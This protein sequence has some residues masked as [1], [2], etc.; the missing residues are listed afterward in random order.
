MPILGIPPPPIRHERSLICSFC[1]V[2]SIIFYCYHVI[3]PNWGLSHQLGSGRRRQAERGALGDHPSANHDVLCILDI[4]GGMMSGHENSRDNRWGGR[5]SLP[6]SV[7]SPFQGSSQ[8]LDNVSD[9]DIPTN[10]PA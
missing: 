4:P 9:S 3:C 5:C 6:L 10:P 2:F 8:A 1:F 7:S